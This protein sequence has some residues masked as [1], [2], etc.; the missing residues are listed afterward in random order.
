MLRSTQLLAV[1]SALALFVPAATAQADEANEPGSTSLAA[2]VQGA[3]L[4]SVPGSAAA[5]YFRTEG[6]VTVMVELTRD[7]VAV[8]D[9][10]KDDA[11]NAV[12]AQQAEVASSIEGKGGKVIT[13]MHSAINAMRV[14]IDA[15]KLSAIEQLE[16]V[17][18]VLDIPVHD[19]VNV[20]GDILVDAP[21]AWGGAGGNGFTGEGVKVAVLDSGIDYTH[22]TFGGAGTK[23]AFDQATAASD[24]AP[25][26]GAHVKGGID[27]VGD[28][29]T[30][31]NTPVPDANPIDCITN[32]HGTHVAGTVGGAGVTPDGRTYE[33]SYD[34]DTLKQ[35]F[36]IGPGAA[37]KSELYA[38]KVFGCKGSTSMVTEAIDWAVKNDMDVINMSLG[39][40][41]GRATDSDSVAATNAVSAGVVV[42]A[43]AG[44]SGPAPYLTGS[45]ASGAGVISV[46][47]VDAV[48]NLPGAVLKSEG[49]TIN[50]INAN[51]GPL[52]L[53]A[54]VHVLKDAA[55]EVSLGCK[56]EDYA[57]I[58]QGSV[59]VTKRGSCARVARAVHAQK[60]GAAAVIMIN[61][62]AALPPFEGPI[63]SNP[64]TGEAFNVTIPFLGVT[65]GDAATVVNLDGKALQVSGSE[66]PN[67]SYRNYTN[68]TSSG[69]RSGDA[70]MRPSL[71]APGESTFSAAVGG[72][73]E[74]IRKSG[75]SMAAP[76]VAGVAA[77]A[78][79]A[80]PDWSAEEISSAL[81]TTAD[82][83]GVNGYQPSRGG[84]LVNASAAVSASVVA[85]G[86]SSQFD[87]QKQAV[88]DA[89]LSFGFDQFADAHEETRT[90]TL[91][92]KG[93]EAVTYSLKDTASEASRKGSISFSSKQVTVPA[94]GTATVDV[95][96]KVNAGDVPTS[97][98]ESKNR[99]WFHEVSG[100]IAFTSDKGTLSVPY[101]LVPRS[102]SEISATAEATGDSSAEIRLANQAGLEGESMLFL[103]GQQ[104]AQDVATGKDS[105][106]DLS[107]VGVSTF[108]VGNERYLAF[109]TAF[110]GRYSNAANNIFGV[111]IDVDGD[112][113]T[114]HRVF[115]ADSG[116]IIDNYSNGVPQVFVA[117][118]KETD[119]AK[120]LQATRLHTVAPTDSAVAILLVPASAIGVTGQFSYTGFAEGRDSEVAAD[121]ID[122]WATYDPTNEPFATDRS[123]KVPA[124]GKATFP[125][126]VNK[127]ALEQQKPLGWQ[128]VVFD[129]VT[130]NESLTGPVPLENQP[131]PTPT[132]APSP[133][134]TQAPTSAPTT[135]APSSPAPSTPAPS[136]PV[137]PTK[138]PVAPG[139]PKTGLN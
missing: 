79:Q 43:S 131:T 126:A 1:A 105:G 28:A 9:G 61:S 57:G 133:T 120:K 31:R 67:S 70:W 14:E 75:T 102:L 41:F 113:S 111:N 122:G 114:D 84:A 100:R 34:A 82:P 65:S 104:D 136:A 35:E 76:V 48:K 90:V 134:P 108:Q 80:H 93:A 109:A 47:A 63:T 8:A 33:G 64:D 5:R 7:P 62:T 12:K 30:G 95:T 135:P 128:V 17:K 55:G 132:P 40:P 54:P 107:Q 77:L 11:E 137:K 16:G 112:G 49:T 60:A 98:G 72:G 37:P 87:G 38:V 10:D 91:E 32:G 139:L 85:Y 39:S 119:D 97:Y 89:T 52:P 24:A 6:P 42:V 69:P 73:T 74:G 103:W 115:S 53:D 45:P 106:F 86:D 66:I 124:G 125:L 46:S 118:P 101:L 15:D 59:V 88:R 23:E 50:G 2:Q 138:P 21:G 4:Q 110:H 44:N 19:R 96:L 18:A 22:A 130:G 94:G 56:E 36:K 83:D 29:Y 68:F 51:N 26:Y 78:R 71:S 13:Q 81:L 116:A 127:T 58:P 3:S 27:L 123:V 99:P 92:N 20:A 117:H 25:F 129:N 121:T